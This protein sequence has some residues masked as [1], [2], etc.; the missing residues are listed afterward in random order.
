MTLSALQDLFSRHRERATGI[1]KLGQDPNRTIFLDNGDIVFAQSTHPLDRLTHLLVERG[2]LTQEQLDYAMGNLKPGL[3]IGKNLIEM[4]FITQ[5]DLLE[6]ARAQVERVVW[7]AL[8]TPD[9]LPDFDARELDATIVRLPMDTP[10]LLLNCLLNLQDRERLLELLGPL[11]QVVALQGRRLLE[12]PLPPDLAKL[13]P[14]LDGS[15]TLLELG[16]EVAVEPIRL[17]ILALFLREVGWAKLHELPP[18]DRQALDLALAPEPQPLSPPLPEPQADA[19]PSLFSTIRA[20]A[21][22]TTNLEHLSEALDTLA[23]EAPTVAHA[24]LSQPELPEATETAPE[25]EGPQAPEPPLPEPDLSLPSQTPREMPPTPNVPLP[26]WP[27]EPEPAVPIETEGPVHDIPES[28]PP[29]PDPPQF[30]EESPSASDGDAPPPR[31]GLRLLLPLL[32]ALALVA[33]GAYWWAGR[34]ARPSRPPEAPTPL[35]Q[36]KATP[37]P[38]G[39]A[40]PSDAPPSASPAPS[41]PATEPAVRPAAP[42]PEPPPPKPPPPKPPP[43][44]PPPPKPSV[45]SLDARLAAITQGN[46]ALATRHGETYRASLSSGRWTLR[47]E[48]ACKAETIRDAV[49]FFGASKPDLWLVPIRLKNGL[50][51]YQVFLGAY[52]NRAAS[53]KAVAGLPA[54]FTAGGN[55]PRPFAVENIPFAQ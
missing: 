32:A 40:V 39:I 44:K 22:P 49:G 38:S 18:L 55:R 5:R 13:P 53:E 36:P 8:G 17:G 7:G 47:L 12:L 42:P 1:W 16:R 24:P 9:A 10:T 29:E 21:A 34:R 19:P 4:G 6:V 14:L 54:P 41:T 52:P 28:V 31:R 35:P 50:S 15:R 23:P 43:P 25:S 48:I 45:P 51:C 3:S 27:E 30:S 26:E 46:L 2:K 20:A 37:P 11:N 33:L